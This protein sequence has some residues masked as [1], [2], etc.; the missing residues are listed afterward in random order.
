MSTA[1]TRSTTQ[2]FRTTDYDLSK[3]FVWHNRFQKATFKNNTGDEKAFEP[4]LVLA[5]D[6][7]DNTIVPLDIANTTNGRNIPVGVLHQPVESSVDGAE[8]TNVSFCTEGDVDSSKL[9]FEDGSSTL[10]TA[11]SQANARTIGDLLLLLAIRPID[12]VENSAFDN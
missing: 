12:T 9:I 6:S 3:I 7:S 2:N 8:T 5:R 1:T 4:G 11:V 10:A